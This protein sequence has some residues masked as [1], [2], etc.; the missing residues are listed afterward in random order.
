MKA[1]G[2]GR[3]MGVFRRREMPKIVFCEWYDINGKVNMYEAVQA[4]L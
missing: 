4:I 2:V 3:K 1:S